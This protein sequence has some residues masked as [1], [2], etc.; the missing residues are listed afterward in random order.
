MIS[1]L[2]ARRIHLGRPQVLLLAL[3]IFFALVDLYVLSTFLATARERD[4]L[5]AQVTTMERAIQRLQARGVGAGFSGA[6]LAVGENPFPRD[7]P[8]AD[9]TNLVVQSARDS[10]VKIETM[11]PQLA[12]GERLATG[13]YRTFRLSLRVTGASQP[14]ADFLSRIERGPVRSWVI[15]NTQ[16]KPTGPGTWDVSFDVTTYAQPG[17]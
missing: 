14:I 1:A 2:R 13:T 10:G 8:S 17:G 3:C 6:P 9:L 15:D 5:F 16:A 4:T 11:T 12:G 7:V